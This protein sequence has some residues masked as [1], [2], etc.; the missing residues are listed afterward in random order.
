MRYIRL[1]IPI[2]KIHTFGVISGSI[3]GGIHMHNSELR[4]CRKFYKNVSTQ[5]LM[6][7][8]MIGIVGGGLVYPFTLIVASIGIMIDAAVYHVKL[9]FEAEQATVV[10]YKK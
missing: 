7:Q 9:K 6:T 1:N 5:D 4:R 10:S 8:T 2:Y 3:I